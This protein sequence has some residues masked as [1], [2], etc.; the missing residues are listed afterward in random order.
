MLY[1]SLRQFRYS[2][3]SIQC[4]NTVD[5]VMEG[6]W[7]VRKSAPVISRASFGDSVQAE[8]TTDN[9]PVEHKLTDLPCHS[10]QQL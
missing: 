4:F 3:S 2:T 6:I 9:K 7:P 10:T 1:V 8:V 5:L